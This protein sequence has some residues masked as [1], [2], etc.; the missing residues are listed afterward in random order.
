M[1]EE[2]RPAATKRILDAARALVARGG[3]GEVSMGE[4]A[5]AAGVSKA[6]VHYH[7]RDKESLM[8]A[9]MDDVGFDVL[10]SAREALQPDAD[11]HALDVYWSWLEREL[12]RG[13]LRVLLSLAEYDSPRVR[14]AARRVADQRRE[15][16]ADHMAQ[17]FAR[18]GL[19]PRVPPALLAET[20]VAFIDGLAAAVALD[21][22]RDP[23]PAFDVLWL[24]LLTLTE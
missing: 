1:S 17:L 14:A 21:D 19:S 2:S 11:A 8:H 22:Q 3:A 5:A 6:L 24:A 16:A 9:L 7:F 20:V 4:V 23:R 18:L 13:D 10:A 15:I 12:R